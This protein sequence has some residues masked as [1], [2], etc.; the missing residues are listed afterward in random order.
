MMRSFGD[1]I[2]MPR[3]TWMG[4]L[5]VLAAHD[6]TAAGRPDMVGHWARGDGNVRVDIEPCGTN[7]C[8]V[9]SW[10]RDKSDGEAIGDKLVM[11]LKPRSDSVLD[12]HAF[13]QKR[14]R[15]YTMRV[16]M[17]LAGKMTTQGCILGGLACK[18]QNWTR[19]K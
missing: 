3:H 13:D 17:Q 5:L 11:M 10:V 14:D 15:T 18:S 7:I 4:F 6:V 9:N 1:R 19:I 12:G 2:A 16:T 8:A